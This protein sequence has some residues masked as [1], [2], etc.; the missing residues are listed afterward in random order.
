M[1]NA[2][3][4]LNDASHYLN[5]ELF[6]EIFTPGTN[7]EM[8]NTVKNVVFPKKA[9]KMIRPTQVLQ[10]VEAYGSVNKINALGAALSIEFDHN[11]YL[12]K[13]DITDLSE[14]RRGEPCL[15]KTKGIG[16]AIIYGDWLQ[17]L[18]QRALETELEMGYVNDTEFANL[19][20][21]R[22]MQMLETGEGQ[23]YEECIKC[24]PLADVTESDV[25]TIHEKKT[26]YY[27]VFA[28]FAY[29]ATVSHVSYQKIIDLLNPLL[30]IGRAFQIKDDILDIVGN[31]TKD[32]A[33]D[34][35]EGKRTL[36]LVKTYQ[37]AKLKEREILAK[38]GTKDD[39]G[40]LLLRKNPKIKENVIR[41]LKKYGEIDNCN[42]IA[43]ELAQEGMRELSKHLPETEGTQD[44]FSLYEFAA[45]T[46]TV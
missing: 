6:D 32:P 42:N 7:P 9:G 27:T 4:I 20:K 31:L 29:G 33:G 26:A 11:A 12:I 41:I 28:P 3:V 19:S 45:I 15:Y 30:K 44:L 17:T 36:H 8:Y 18:A 25:N 10:T 22:C 37:Q 2:Q 43:K 34:L 14:L 16:R 13:D 38:C 24:K 5:R 1:M 46:R 40:N 39:D 35:E 23:D 21:I